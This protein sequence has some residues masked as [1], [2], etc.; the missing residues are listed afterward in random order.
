[1]AYLGRAS[2]V[3]RWFYHRH[4]LPSLFGDVAMSE[5]EKREE[6]LKSI[7]ARFHELMHKYHHAQSRADLAANEV[8]ELLELHEEIR[9]QYG[10]MFGSR[11]L[12][13]NQPADYPINPTL[14]EDEA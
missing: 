9:N 12:F 1:M 7:E 6:F 3:H 2:I 8:R 10:R 4:L 14:A 5:V 11:E 13:N